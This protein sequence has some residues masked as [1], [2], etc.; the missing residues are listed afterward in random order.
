MSTDAPWAFPLWLE[1]PHLTLR[2]PA[3]P[4][5]PFLP[6]PQPPAGCSAGSSA[7]P[8]SKPDCSTPSDPSPLC[9]ASLTLANSW[10][11]LR[12]I[13]F[14]SCSNQWVPSPIP[15]L[16]AFQLRAN[17]FMCLCVE[18]P[19]FFRLSHDSARIYDDHTLL[20]HS[21]ETESAATALQSSI[22]SVRIAPTLP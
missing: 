9:S 3:P 20:S 18:C 1:G 10:E 2:T 13:V 14:Q 6:V 4:V 21:V 17:W 22:G 5:K 12:V 8:R 15:Q 7:A 19:H 16:I 11:C